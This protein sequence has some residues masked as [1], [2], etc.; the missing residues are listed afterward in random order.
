MASELLQTI[1]RDEDERAR[2]HSRR[3]FEM[4][5]THNLL[6][7]RDERSM[8]IAKNALDMDMPI[9]TIVK[10]TGLTRREVESLRDVD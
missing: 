7:T 10:L 3:K 5:M 8:E 9:D 4:D 2:F 6:A 1:S